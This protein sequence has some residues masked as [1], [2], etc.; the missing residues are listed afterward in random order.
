MN[1]S[2][3]RHLPWLFVPVF[4]IVVYL[5]CQSWEYASVGTSVTVTVAMVGAVIAARQLLRRDGLCRDALSSCVMLI[6]FCSLMLV[7]LSVFDHVT[8]DYEWFLHPW[9]ERLRE[10]GGIAGLSEPLGNYNVPYLTWLAVFSY[11]PIHDLYL[12]KLLSIMF[13]VML[14]YFLFKLAGE[15]TDNP[16]ARI[17]CFLI[18]L[19]LPT[20]ILNGAYWGQ[21]DSI[22]AALCAA[23]LYFAVRV[24][25]TM[26]L[27]EN[28]TRFNS[29]LCYVFAALALGYKLQAIF[30]MPI[31]IPL[32]LAKRLSLK[33]VWVFPLTY[34]AIVAPALL[35]GRS[36]TEVLTF[37]F[38]QTDSIG[39][40]LNYNSPSIFALF[41][42]W[43]NPAMWEKLGI[44]F[45]GAVC[46]FVVY[47]AYFRRK[48]LDTFT[49]LLLTGILA[50]G[51]P[52]FLPRMH[53]RYFFLA[54]VLLLPLAVTYPTI[55]G[56]V[57][58]C[59]FASLLGYHAYLRQAWLL[60]MNYGFFAIA[61]AMLILLI[62][63]LFR[64]PKPDTERLH[65]IR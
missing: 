16:Y 14:A 23:A 13:D 46:A 34:L 26:Q 38:V 33:Y 19:V 53:D 55:A 58:L 39:E 57:A 9:V 25:K 54:D 49:L 31:I 59:G 21:C 61:A 17:L 63:L 48:S 1:E 10:T 62:T 12:I 45:A 15:L 29:V 27:R 20:P 8:L 22:Y 32:L 41:W 6:P 64:R 42:E 7:R 18:A 47:I 4:G 35:A 36:I 60:T 11:I 50:V 28:Y 65:K 52:M 30:I 44:V 43:D 24:P 51:V 40:G 37:Y 56:A 5:C 2:P 3:S